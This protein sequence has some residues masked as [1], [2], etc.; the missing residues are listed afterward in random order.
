MFFSKSHYGFFSNAM[1]SSMPDD[2]IEITDEDYEVAKDKISEG[3]VII[4]VDNGGRILFS[5]K[6]HDAI[7]LSVTRAQ[8][9]AALI[10]AGLWQGVVDFV[11]SISDPVEKAVAEVALND[12]T[13]WQRTSPFLN[14]AANALGLTDEQLDQLF[15]EA[16]KIE[17]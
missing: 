5:E 1:H 16:S 12:T 2:C 13:H 11:N 4:G 14:E 10:R 15:I 3:F 17:L 7:V 9:K 6:K 8:G